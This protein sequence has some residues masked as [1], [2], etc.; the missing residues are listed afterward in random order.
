MKIKVSI[1]DLTKAEN[2]L[3]SYIASLNPK[4]T[5]LVKELVTLGEKEALATTTELGIMFTGELRA[6]ISGVSRGTSGEVVCESDHAALVEFGSGLVEL[7]GD[8]H[9]LRDLM[10]MGAGTYPGQKH[11]LDPKGWWYPVDDSLKEDILRSAGQPLWLS[12][13]GR[14]YAHTYGM[15]S[16]PFM[17]ITSMAMRNSLRKTARRIFGT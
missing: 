10:G 9:P 12:P 6:G 7:M 15:V 16:R 1:N 3:D 11:A 17:Y 4:A 2:L 13:D 8:P 5:S 14:L